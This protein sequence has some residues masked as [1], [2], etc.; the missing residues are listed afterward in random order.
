[1]RLCNFTD[2]ELKQDEWSLSKPTFGVEGQLKV[3]G[4]V[5]RNI[6]HKTC[7]LECSICK[8]DFELFG[9]GYFK[10]DKFSLLNGSIPCGCANKPHWNN[11]QYYTLCSRKAESLGYEFLGFKGN[12]KGAKTKVILSCDI[13]G[14]WDTSSIDK[15]RNGRGCPICKLDTISKSITKSDEIMVNSFLISG[16]FHP[17][18]KFWRS[19]KL[20]S[21]GHRVYWF[22][23][24]PECGE[25]GESLSGDLQKGQRS[26]ACSKQRQQEAYINFIT[27]NEVPICIKFGVAV[28][29]SRRVLQ[30]NSKTHLDIKQFA[31][32]KFKDVYSCK[33]AEKECK[34]KLDTAVISKG[35]MP[36]GWTE[37][38][39]VYNLDR[40]VEIYER[41]GGVKID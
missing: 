7:L 36:D 8:E 9:E 2:V 16:S 29:S 11:E 5:G 25:V 21:R 27:D 24:C 3:V 10:S 28:N 4:L 17:D 6:S 22:M 13:H 26:C 30:Q 20:N 38:T 1:M 41:N 32:Y 35:D 12:W 23:S 14:E 33:L 34:D 15:L 39:W 19:E 18:T 37:T 40:V 31:V